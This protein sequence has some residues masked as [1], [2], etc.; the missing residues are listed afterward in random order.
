MSP[1]AAAER[2]LAAALV[3]VIV[4]RD[5]APVLRLLGGDGEHLDLLTPA[6]AVGDID[7]RRHR[8]LVRRRPAVV[9]AEVDEGVGARTGERRRER[10]GDDGGDRGERERAEDEAR[11]GERRVRGRVD[12]NAARRRVRSSW[13]CNAR[14][15]APVMTIATGRAHR[16]VGGGRERGDPDE[17]RDPRRERANRRVSGGTRGSRPIRPSPTPRALRGGSPRDAGATGAVSFRNPSSP[18]SSRCDRASSVRPV[19]TPD[20]R[21]VRQQHPEDVRRESGERQAHRW[22]VIAAAARARAP[23]ACGAMAAPRTARPT[24]HQR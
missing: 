18:A 23:I 12:P 13:C 8:R 22:R 20:R 11:R 7:E 4:E 1:P 16:A 9:V 10:N 3:G 19:G 24:R 14:N 17:Q 6:Q 5:G 2:P 15:P 21:R